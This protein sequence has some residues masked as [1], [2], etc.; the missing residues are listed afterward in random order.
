MSA[1]TSIFEKKLILAALALGITAA[2]MWTGKIEPSTFENVYVW[3]CGVF[4]LG[5]ASADWAKWFMSGQ[6]AQA[7]QQI[8]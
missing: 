2:M 6:S 7:S 3:I 8:K 4:I 1:E 5:E